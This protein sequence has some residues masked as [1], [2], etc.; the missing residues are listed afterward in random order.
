MHV[1]LDYEVG[2]LAS[3]ARGFKRAGMETIISKDPAVIQRAE[4]LILPGVGAFED[5]MISLRKSNL[6]PLIEAHV[7]KGKY[8]LGICLGMQL[9]FEKSFE[10]G[11]F[12]GLG[13][14]RGTID[15][16]NIPLKVPHMGWNELI[17]NQP[18]DK[19]L[20]RIAVNDNV[21]F[22]HSYYANADKADVVAYTNY[23]IDMPAIV[24]KGNIYGMQF[25]PEKSGIVG[26]NL[27]KAYGALFI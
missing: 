18:N 15:Y 2:N 20:N 4:S 26:L 5:A 25:H 12:E 6:I 16:M 27:L 7:Q 21:Y 9:L 11:V 22:V 8:L 19:I 1:I 10:N 23:G 14:M 3:V 24:K 17:F 13:L